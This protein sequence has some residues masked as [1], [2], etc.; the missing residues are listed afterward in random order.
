MRAGKTPSEAA[1]EAIG[2]IRRVYPRF[3]GAIVA[4]TANGQYGAACAGIGGD[5]FGYSVVDPATEGK[6][7]VERVKCQ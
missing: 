5:E 7:R 4:A 1:S 6:V 2:R 3:M